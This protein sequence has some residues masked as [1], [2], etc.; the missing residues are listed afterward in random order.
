MDDVQ[1]IPL[2]EM[3]LEDFMLPITQAARRHFNTTT[4]AAKRMILRRSGVI[5]ILTS[6]A[7]R[8][9]RHRMGGF[10]LG[11][12]AIEVLNRTL[13]HESEPSPSAGYLTRARW[14]TVPV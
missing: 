10:S 12:A 3:Q 11:C 7:A 5:V 8:E 9:W 6:S 14:A 4:A 2:H 13:A 1:G